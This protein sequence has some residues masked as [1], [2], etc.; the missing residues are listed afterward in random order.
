MSSISIIVTSP[1][2]DSQMSYH[3]AQYAKAVVNSDNHQ[4]KGVFFYG[5][6]VLN[7]NALNLTLTD[8]HN[9]CDQWKMLARDHQVP[10]Y[11]CVTA[12]NARGV[13]SKQDASDAD[14]EQYSLAE[15]AISCGLGE[16]VALSEDADRV[17]Q[18]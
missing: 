13:L 3:A 8:I 1:P 18:F 17:V 11:V 7:T 5:S 12:A 10:M 16:W 14:I 6:G 15:W 4:L 2:Y 9:V